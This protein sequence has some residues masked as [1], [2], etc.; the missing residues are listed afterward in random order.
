[1]VRRERTADRDAEIRAWRA[2]GVPVVEIARRVD[3]TRQA[4]YDVLRR[5]K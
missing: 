5:V 3:L 4:V 1:M 2:A